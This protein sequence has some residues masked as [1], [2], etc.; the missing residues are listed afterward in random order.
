MLQLVAHN[1]DYPGNLQKHP[2]IMHIKG[3]AGGKAEPYPFPYSSSLFL[4]LFPI[5]MIPVLFKLPFLNY[6]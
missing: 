5:P 4:C 3:H 1:R 6:L 2:N